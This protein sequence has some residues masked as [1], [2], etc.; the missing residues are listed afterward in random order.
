VALTGSSVLK[1]T[2]GGPQTVTERK[3]ERWNFAIEA[4][5]AADT[6][7]DHRGRRHS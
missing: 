3:M 7:G 1:L 2:S 5:V 4:R 6:D